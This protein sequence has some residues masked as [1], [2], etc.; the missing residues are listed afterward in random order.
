[1]CIDSIYG[2]RNHIFRSPL[3]NK[4]CSLSSNLLDIF[5]ANAQRDTPYGTVDREQW[6]G[7][8]SAAVKSFLQAKGLVTV[9]P[10]KK[11]NY[12]QLNTRNII[13]HPTYKF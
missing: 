10:T 2:C 3:R 9:G 13:F 5:I 7:P 1:M 11:G 12:T 4:R 8:L 6:T